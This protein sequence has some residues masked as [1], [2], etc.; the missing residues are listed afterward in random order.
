VVSP[1]D[2]TVDGAS[3]NRAIQVP[4]FSF[5]ENRVKPMSIRSTLQEKTGRNEFTVLYDEYTLKSFPY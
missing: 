5:T 2:L 1:P 4:F 3:E